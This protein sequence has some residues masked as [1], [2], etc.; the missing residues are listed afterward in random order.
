M[1]PRKPQR[2]FRSGAASPGR[3]ADGCWP[4]LVLLIAAA[5]WFI[6]SGMT[7]KKPD[8]V[9]ATVT[10][11]NLEQSVL[12]TGVL[13]PFK[14][15]SV[16]AQ[17]SGQ[18]KKLYVELGQTVKTGDPIAD[19][20]NRAR[21]PTRWRTPMLASPTSRRRRP[22]L[23]PR[24]S[25]RAGSTS[26]AR[27]GSMMPALRPRRIMTPP[28]RL[29]PRGGAGAGE[30]GQRPDQAGQSDPQ[31]GADQPWLHQDPGADGRRDRR[32]DHPGRPDGERQPVDADHRHAGASST[33]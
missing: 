13:E 16:G 31:H 8:I 2:A 27:S 33:R 9:T 1:K 24:L 15:I 10:R 28:H 19:I 12:A 22:R 11:G 25:N 14:L 6:Y 26:I 7:A 32:A 20:D 21:R 17:A 4:S 3:R 29:W 30:G 23:R 18:V 5:G